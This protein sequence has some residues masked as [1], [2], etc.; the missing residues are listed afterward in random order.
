MREKREEGGDLVAADCGAGV[1]RITK[2]LLAKHFTEVD[3]IEPVEHFLTKAKENLSAASPSSKGGARVNFLLQGLQ[4]VEAKANRYD[5]VWIQWCIGHLTDEDCVDFL[6]VCA[7]SLRPQGMIVVKENNARR[8][9]VLDKDDS[10]ITRSD[11]YLVQLFDKAN[12]RILKSSV[13]NDLPEG[14]FI[15][16]AYAL[17]PR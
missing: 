10:G 12:L 17:V 13:E 8:G 16:R 15:V 11:S 2:G 6:R 9:F 14:L 1:G 4:D 3:V 5:V 7:Q